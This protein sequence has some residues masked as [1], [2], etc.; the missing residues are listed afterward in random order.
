MV[1]YC[2]LAFLESCCWFAVLLC[3]IWTYK[4]TCWHN[5]PLYCV[6]FYFS[7][8]EKRNPSQE[9][10]LPWKSRLLYKVFSSL[11]STTYGVLGAQTLFLELKDPTSHLLFNLSSFL[12][13][14]P[15][16][17]PCAIIHLPSLS[18]CFY[19]GCLSEAAPS[20]RNALVLVALFWQNSF[21]V[22]SLEF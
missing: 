1:P 17:W 9:S 14:Q 2:P 10:S 5:H 11:T 16:L 6:C 3:R 7:P 13:T 15:S 20:A 4:H 21:L 18:Q 12:P 22:S 19:A 8:T